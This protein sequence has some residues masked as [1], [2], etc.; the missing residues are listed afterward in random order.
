MKFWNKIEVHPLS[1]IVITVSLLTGLF[2]YLIL[3]FIIIIIHECG[4]IMM[5]KYFKRQIT[6][7][8]ILPFGG[9]MKMDSYISSDIF[10]DLLIA[11]GGILFN[12]ILGIVTYA[13]FNLGI[14][15]Y[16]KYNLIKTYNSIVIGF[17]LLPICPLDGYKMLK[18]LEEII[19]SFKKTFIISFVISVSILSFLIIDDVSLVRNNILVFLFLIFMS[20][21]ELKNK[22]YILNRFYL[23]RLNHDF[24]FYRNANIKNIDGMYK[25]RNNYLNEESEHIFL[26]RRYTREKL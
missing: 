23:E 4:H 12:L 19:I 1:Y 16:D 20:I 6:S 11:V 14:L 15:D 17:N 18:L 5:A 22:I 2:K 8:S 7:I 13:L 3:V 21:L 9:L 10:E 25:N 26:K 24:K